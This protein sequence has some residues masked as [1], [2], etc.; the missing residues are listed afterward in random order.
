[1]H[2]I[3]VLKAE[4]RKLRDELNTKKIQLLEMSEQYDNAINAISATERESERRQECMK[5]TF[6][7]LLDTYFDLKNNLIPLKAKV[8]RDEYYLWMEN[9]GLLE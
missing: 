5:K 7:K 4:L 9:A 6:I 1:M 2:D 8:R 3:D